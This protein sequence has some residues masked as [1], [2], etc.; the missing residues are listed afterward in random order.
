MATVVPV[1]AAA[2]PMVCCADGLA[3]PAGAEI[4]DAWAGCPA[5]TAPS[6]NAAAAAA[7]PTTPTELSST[8]LPGF[9]LSGNGSPALSKIPGLTRACRAPVLLSPIDVPSLS[10]RRTSPP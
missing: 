3:V 4:A 10:G 6:V 7:M 9:G 2:D 5:P 8:P 1:V